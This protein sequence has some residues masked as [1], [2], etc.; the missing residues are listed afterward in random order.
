MGF[1][2]GGLSPN[3][4][5]I[6]RQLQ[7]E[8]IKVLRNAAVKIGQGHGIAESMKWFGDDSLMW[9]ATVKHK[10]EKLASLINVKDIKVG[11]SKLG[12]RCS[13]DFASAEPPTGGWEDY[14]QWSNVMSVAQGQ[15]FRINLNLS[16]NSA[17]LYRPINTP[18]DSKFQTLVHECTHLFI[19]TDDDAYG[20]GTCLRTAV[21]SPDL[22]KKTADCWGYFVEEFR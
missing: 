16:W 10:L 21:Q 2:D 19:E 20:V 9:R 15:N 4:L 17:P 3:D 14:T 7:P 6:V 11:F 5:F 12:G 22:A 8:I 18:A 13:D 1:L